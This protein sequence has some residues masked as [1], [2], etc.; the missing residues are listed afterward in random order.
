[1]HLY[2][3][4]FLLLSFFLT[5]LPF[6]LLTSSVFVVPFPNLL[7]L[8]LPM[9]CIQLTLWLQLTTLNF[10]FSLFLLY[11]PNLFHSPILQSSLL[12]LCPCFLIPLLSTYCKVSPWIWIIR[13][14]SKAAVSMW[15]SEFYVHTWKSHPEESICNFSHVDITL[16]C[17]LTEQ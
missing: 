2:C 17:G 4:F 14:I 7:S 6:L 15:V 12:A 5:V 16:T 9:Y 1:M 11:I 3:M 8:L 13:D 10:A